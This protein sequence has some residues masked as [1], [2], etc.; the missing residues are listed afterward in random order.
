[1]VGHGSGDAE[2]GL[3]HIEAADLVARLPD[4]ATGG[5]VSRIGEVAILGT[6]EVA[7]HRKNGG[8]PGK[9]G[10]ELCACAERRGGSLGVVS[11]G[12]RL[13]DSPGGLRILAGQLRAEALP[14]RGDGL[15]GENG[16]RGAT[17]SGRFGTDPLNFSLQLFGGGLFSLEGEM[18]ATSGIVKIKNGG[19][20]MVVA[21][22]FAGRV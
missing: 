6:E 10:A 13:I 17:G 22:A 20:G 15:I 11:R 18:A 9:V 12:Q 4:P 1:M 5:K 8:G 21:L 14:G 3:R 2:P 19:L 16:E 7:V